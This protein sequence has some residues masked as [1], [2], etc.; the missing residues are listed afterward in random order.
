[1]VL[2]GK[3]EIA[4]KRHAF[5]QAMKR[6]ISPDIIEDVIQQGKFKHF[7]KNNVKIVKEFNKM[8]VTCV[9]EIIGNVIKIV[10]ITKKVKK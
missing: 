3:Y 7:G 9:D 2:K 8:K 5:I 1:M 10:T 4:I 6:G